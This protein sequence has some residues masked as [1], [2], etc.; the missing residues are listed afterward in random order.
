VGLIIVGAANFRPTA[1]LVRQ[2][3]EITLS[4]YEYVR[5]CIVISLCLYLFQI[6]MLLKTPVVT[7]N[8]HSITDFYTQILKIIILATT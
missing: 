7:F 1:F 2:K 5:I 4:L 3:K 8:G 6:C